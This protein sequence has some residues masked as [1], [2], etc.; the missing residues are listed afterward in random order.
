[1]GTARLEDQTGHWNTITD[2]S[3][4]T[5]SR[6]KKSEERSWLDLQYVVGS[7]STQGVALVDVR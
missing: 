6:Y 2:L 7:G 3:L 1:M 5:R 4:D